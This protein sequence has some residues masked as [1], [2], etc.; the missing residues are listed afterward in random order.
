MLAAEHYPGHFADFAL[1]RQKL[2][3]IHRSTIS[4]HYAKPNYNY[5]MI[6][7]PYYLAPLVGMPTRIYQT[8][9]DGALAFL[10]VVSSTRKA[11]KINAKLEKN[12]TK[13]AKSL[14]LDMAK[15]G[16]SN[17]REQSKGRSDF[18]FFDVQFNSR[19]RDNTSFKTI[20]QL[21][22]H[23]AQLAVITRLLRGGPRTPIRVSANG[24]FRA[25]YVLSQKAA[26]A[27]KPVAIYH[28]LVR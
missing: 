7:L 16:R 2:L 22:T 14:R 1:P 6:R 8:V 20:V 21:F 11:A 23:F 28:C 5:P 24:Y 18:R 15:V 26:L 9:H 3:E 25:A 10:V 12:T 27:G 17:R 13:D 19:K 4:L